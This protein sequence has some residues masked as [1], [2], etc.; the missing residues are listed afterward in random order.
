M[1]LRLPAASLF[2][3][4][5]SNCSKP[6]ILWSTRN[7]IIMIYLYIYVCLCKCANIHISAWFK[8]N[9]CLFSNVNIKRIN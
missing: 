1:K 4:P 9:R 7:M 3:D 6:T 5:V 8:T 2:M